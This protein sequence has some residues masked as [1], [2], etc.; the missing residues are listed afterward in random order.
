MITNKKNDLQA[1]LNK[2]GG[3]LTR[4]KLII[5]D[6][7]QKNHNHPTAEVIYRTVRKKLPNISLGTIYRNLNYLA[8]NDFLIELKSKYDNKTHF[9]INNQDH[10][11]FICLNCGIIYDIKRFEKILQGK[12]KNLG[13][14][15]RIE[16][17]LYGICKQCR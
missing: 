12:F 7:L 8:E 11:H 6:F 14:I 1:C 2:N 16:C 3:R 4:Q 13:K 9:D 17:S 5:L 10:L 15:N